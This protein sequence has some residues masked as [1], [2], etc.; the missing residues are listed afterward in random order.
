MT[1]VTPAEGRPG[2]TTSGRRRRPTGAP[3]PLPRQIGASGRVFIAGAYLRCGWCCSPTTGWAS[4]LTE[5]VDA[6][7]LR[8]LRPDPAPG[9]P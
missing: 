8:R 6:A 5:Q 2:A 3:A 1:I 7:V 4:E 9:G